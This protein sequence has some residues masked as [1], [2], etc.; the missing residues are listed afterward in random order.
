MGIQFIAILVAC[1]SAHAA[2]SR[3]SLPRYVAASEFTVAHTGEH[4]QRI[5]SVSIYVACL[6]T[7][8]VVAVVSLR[9]IFLQLPQGKPSPPFILQLRKCFAHA[10]GVNERQLT[11]IPE[12]GRVL[13]QSLD[14]ARSFVLSVKMVKG[15][16]VPTY[17]GTTM[18]GVETLVSLD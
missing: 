12:N 17:C 5:P 16:T 9:L 11:M 15:S 14:P 7:G 1:H 3:V 18:A 8:I 10:L 13:Q 4:W 2:D 6:V